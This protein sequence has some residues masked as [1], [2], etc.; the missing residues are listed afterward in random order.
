MNT[1]LANISAIPNFRDARSG[2][3]RPNLL[4]RAVAW[5]ADLPRRRRDAAELAQ[6]TDRELADIGLTRSDI[7]HIQSPEFAAEYHQ[8]RNS[9]M[10]L[11]RA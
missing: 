7:D 9:A 10:F 5:L 2:D 3:A 1:H 6:F 8:G 11:I 4:A